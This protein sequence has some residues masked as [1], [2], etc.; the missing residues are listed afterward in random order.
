MYDINIKK[1]KK[2]ATIYGIIFL[3]IIGFFPFIYNLLSFSLYYDTKIDSKMKS[4]TYV[5]DK[6]KKMQKNIYYYEVKGNNYQYVRDIKNKN[7]TSEN[8][9]DVVIYCNSK[10]IIFFLMISFSFFTIIGIWLFFLYLTIREIN[11]IKRINKLQ[12]NGKLIKDYPYKLVNNA[13]LKFSAFD[14]AL[15][16][17]EV[18]KG[19]SISLQGEIRTI[20]QTMSYEDSP[21]DFNEKK[22]DILIDEDDPTT[23][24][25]DCNINN[26]S[27]K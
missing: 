6:N 12:K 14:R 17:Y 13:K 11:V 25:L 16:N 15:V 9:K 1:Y 2:S 7:N 20:Y 23:Y 19:K 10:D 24:V 4:F 5:D 26:I 18:E 8:Y 3:C 27:K 21:Y 22:I